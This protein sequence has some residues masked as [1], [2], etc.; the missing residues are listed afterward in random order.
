MI[1]AHPSGRAAVLF[2]QI[3]MITTGVDHST[4]LPSSSR[5]RAF[6]MTILISSVV[7]RLRRVD[8]GEFRVQVGRRSPRHFVTTL[9]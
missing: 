4:K 3:R 9:G 5:F 2:D 8:W 1:G 7:R 6:T